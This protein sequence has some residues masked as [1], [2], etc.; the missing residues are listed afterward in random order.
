[1]FDWIRHL[2]DFILHIDV[3]L[4]EIIR[5]YGAWTYGILFL[6]VFVETGLVIMPFL[7]G[8]SLLFAAGA[9]AAKGSL[10]VASV[11]LLLI[12]A[13]VIGDN[14][15]YFVGRTLGRR[16]KGIPL[17]K[18]EY[19]ERTQ[20]FYDKHGGKTLILARFM[21]IIRTFAPFVA[22]VGLMRY[23]KFLAYSVAGG[24]AWVSL[25][26]MSGYLFGGIPWIEEHF[27]VVVIAIV[28][29]SVMPAVIGL[30]RSKLRA[31]GA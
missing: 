19:L 9:F 18:Q 11:I 15:N 1:M 8:D 10:N 5:S 23:R 14:V 24:T 3:H 16:E 20:A 25:M 29:I 26:T 12:A 6:I 17:V 28:L 4:D 30:V 2:I 13:A 7:P 22:G 27:S 21:P 31:R